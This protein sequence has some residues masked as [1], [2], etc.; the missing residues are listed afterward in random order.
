MHLQKRLGNLAAAFEARATELTKLKEQMRRTWYRPYVWCAVHLVSAQDGN[1]TV[2]WRVGCDY[3]PFYSC[4]NWRQMTAEDLEWLA[5]KRRA[6]ELWCKGELAEL[7]P[8]DP[9]PKG[10]DK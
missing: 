10:E 8:S 7:P 2:E 6:F 9:K 3:T 1:A 5:Q 4:D